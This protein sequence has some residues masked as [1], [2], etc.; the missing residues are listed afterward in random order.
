ME[1]YNMFEPKI[2]ISEALY[3]KLKQIA[4]VRGYSS[5]EE[6]AVHI[7]ETAVMITDDAV[8]EE[9]VKKRLQGLGYLG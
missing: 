9:E 8:S 3:E 1:R 5:P 4:K 7:L 6:F 2:K